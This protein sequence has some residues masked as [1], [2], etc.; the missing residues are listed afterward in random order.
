MRVVEVIWDDA[1]VSTSEM[2]IKKAEKVKPIR[3]H[4]VAFLL[5]ENDEGITLATD[6]YPSSPKVG[7][8]INHIPW[9]MVVNWYEYK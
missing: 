9:G 4:T 6:T 1:H 3:T 2:S 7:K 5:A 8:I